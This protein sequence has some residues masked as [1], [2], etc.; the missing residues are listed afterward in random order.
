MRIWLRLVLFCACACG[1]GTTP[2]R[3]EP[4]TNGSLHGRLP[5]PS[6]NPWNQ[7]VDRAPVD[8][9]SK[10]LIGSIGADTPL[11]PDFGSFWEGQPLGIP[12]VVVDSHTPRQR[13]HFEYAEE[14]DPGPYPI[15]AR[16]AVEAGDD[17]HLLLIDRDQWKLYELYHF[18]KDSRK[19]GSGAIFDLSSNRL[20]PAGWTSADAA[21]LPIFPGLVRYDEVV[22]AGEIRHALR[23][24]VSRSR[25]AYLAPARHQAG[26][27][28]D[29]NLPPMGMRV[30][31]KA[32]YDISGFPAQA[33]VILRALKTYGMICADNGSDWFI[34]GTHDARW[35]DEQL[36]SLK[37]VTGKDLEVIKM[38]GPV[39]R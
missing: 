5:F 14:S 7:P 39:G 27:S 28:D 35:N 38:S 17:H 1:A 23:Y 31:L 36:S 21:G 8:P 34:S 26:A 32:D 20:R 37:R 15:P 19:A 18:S 22:E 11:H 2:V 6:D 33:Q 9:N 25:R 30:R 12:Y 16:P 24:T 3:P 10:N 13:L 29:P 4:G